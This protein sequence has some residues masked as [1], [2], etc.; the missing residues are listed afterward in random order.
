MTAMTVPEPPEI[1]AAELR[2]Y[3]LAQV[4]RLELAVQPIRHARYDPIADEADAA[5]Q[6]EALETRVATLEGRALL[7]GR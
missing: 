2:A 4:E 6:R 5:R 7:G 1:S 3:V